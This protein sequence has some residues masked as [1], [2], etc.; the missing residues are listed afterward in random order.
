[1]NVDAHREAKAGDKT[2]PTAPADGLDGDLD[3]APGQVFRSVY[4]FFYNKRVGLALI[5]LASFC[6]LLGV[7]FPQMTAGTRR[8]PAAREQ[9]LLQ[10]RDDF[11]GWT[12]VL[13]FIGVFH[14]FSSVPFLVV[15][16]LLAVSILACTTHRI[17]ILKQA[18]FHPHTRV[19]ARFFE[20][21]RLHAAIG[22]AMSA[23]ETMEAFKADAA[24][25]RC[26]M[27]DDERGPGLNVYTDHWH[28]APFGTV[29]A[30]IAFVVIMAGFV[31]TATTGFRDESF[32]LTVGIPAEVGYQTGLVAEAKDF[33]DAYYEDGTPKDYVTDLVLVRDGREVARQD[34][35][36]NHPLIYQ[37]VYFYQASFG[38]AGVIEVRDASGATVFSDGVPLQ[39]ATQDGALAYGH[40]ELADQGY[41]VYVVGAASGA[42][43]TG[44]A[45]GQMRI[46]VYP[47][48]SNSPVASQV[49]DQGESLQAERLTVTFVREAAYTG[50]MVKKDPGTPIVWIG[51]ALL[52]IG[53]FLTM[54]LRHH[55]IWA[56]V[57]SDEDGVRLLLASPDRSDPSFSRRFRELEARMRDCLSG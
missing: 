38:V 23:E 5:L 46:E 41:E 30:H 32:T 50:I 29:I 34:V 8:N 2:D 56:R 51:C 53:T 18:A 7:V 35:R 14:I 6:A 10:A 12:G 3:I 48:E 15:M 20:H 47:L 26:R 9:W 33:T 21:A 16:G 45:P 40:V 55:R 19:T 36:V 4:A 13:D 44:I 1:M 37:G 52:V 22:S 54:F 24:G 31:V 27:I 43:G 49:V 11:G 25:R 42:V 17:P 28:L 39:W 57:V